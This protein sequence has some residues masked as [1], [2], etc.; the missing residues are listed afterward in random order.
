MPG[1]KITIESA[2]I[3][4]LVML[5]NTVADD[6][7]EE[8]EAGNSEKGKLYPKELMSGTVFNSSILYNLSGSL[9]HEPHLVKVLNKL[10]TFEPHFKKIDYLQEDLRSFDNL[11]SLTVLVYQERR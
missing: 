10:L 7:E 6:G 8:N 3:T 11:L 4:N 9:T 5:S 2:D 1:K